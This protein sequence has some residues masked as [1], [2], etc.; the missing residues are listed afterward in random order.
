MECQFLNNTANNLNSRKENRKCFL[1]F[2]PNPL[3]NCLGG[4]QKNMSITLLEK[5]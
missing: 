2:N 4:L 3:I 1:I 5:K